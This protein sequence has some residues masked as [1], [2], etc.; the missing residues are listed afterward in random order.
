MGL[1][2]PVY[3]WDP[4]HYIHDIWVSDDS[5]D[6]SIDF[7]CVSECFEEV[8]R[9]IFMA[10]LEEFEGPLTHFYGCYQMTELTIPE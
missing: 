4:S 5:C 2:V 3:S 6:L 7:G 1:D 9:D 10:E 8:D